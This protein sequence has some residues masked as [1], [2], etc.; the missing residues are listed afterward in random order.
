MSNILDR[1][2]KALSFKGLFCM[3]MAML[4]LF[5]C[6]GFPLFAK[7]EAEAINSAS[8]P[9]NS[10]LKT[11]ATTQRAK[12]DSNINYDKPVIVSMGDSF[13][14]GEG[15]EDFY[16]QD[17]SNEKKVQS[18][19][20]LAHRSEL[21][22]PGQ[23]KFPG[24]D[25]VTKEYKGGNWRFVASSGATTYHI[26]NEQPKD[27]ARGI[28]NQFTDE[29][30]EKKGINTK[31]Y[32]QINVFKDLEK[33]SV[34]YV[35]LTI[36]GNDAKFSAIIKEAVI[37]STYLNLSSLNNM[38]SDVWK[39]FYKDEGI[40]DNIYKTYKDIEKA[41]GKQAQIIVAGYPRLLNENGW[42]PPFSKEEAQEINRAVSNFN[43]EIERIVEQ[44]A[45]EDMKICF[46]SV[47]EEFKDRGAYSWNSYINRVYLTPQDEDLKN[48]RVSS[49]Y[50]IH[51]NKEGAK[52]YARC[53]N[54]K[55][56]EL[57]Q[58]EA[59]RIEQEALNPSEKD[60]E[61]VL[62]LDASGSMSGTPLEE[63]KSAAHKFVD[64]VLQSDANIG[65]VTYDDIAS[66]CSAMTDSKQ[67]LDNAID[68]I[69]TGGSTNI[70]DGLKMADSMLYESK[71][72][73][74]IIVLM[75]D[76]LPNCG[77]TGDSLISYANELKAKGYYIYTL[78]FFSKVSNKS[79]PEA[80]MG[81]IASEGCHYEVTD[82]ESLVFFFGDIADQ[83]SGTNFIYVRIA[84][85]V[86]V[87][88]TYNGETL[89]SVD[90]YKS[91]RTSF[92]SITFEENKK[93]ESESDDYYS[94]DYYS[95][96]Y[97]NEETED[98]QNDDRIKILRLKEGVDY[99]V[100]IEGNGEGEMDYTIGFM[101]KNG[102]YSDMRDF[103]DV[104]ITPDTVIDTVATVSD[105][106]LMYVDEDGDGEYDITYKAGVNEIAEEV[107]EEVVPEVEEEDEPNYP[108]INL[109]VIGGV[110]LL[111][112]LILIAIR[113]S[114]IKK[115]IVYPTLQTTAA[116]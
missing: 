91:T 70:E 27:F 84:C 92:G 101:D 72:T 73:K 57:A 24:L 83:I 90:N 12:V 18:Q 86:D 39:D 32:P 60:R 21:S 34:D 65:I 46:V 33:E 82:A 10:T 31:I 8:A 44:C 40:R 53:V 107:K 38:L 81:A 106:T 95:D 20:W 29:A 63:T 45:S 114:K 52:A 41:A 94:D 89:T 110:I 62:V 13:S 68:S 77:K 99:D 42:G 85:P 15:I 88:V 4:L 74:K 59:D 102:E 16:D 61:I 78:G 71:A 55:I 26:N 108:L 35:T 69:N 51:P 80:L 5:S 50:S 116:E 112:V 36:G 56:A 49:D 115:F 6:A 75:S 67:Y 3:F 11:A 37:G 79:E 97:S 105:N 54:T 100:K 25:D 14:A 23:L 2:D 58:A 103:F 104:E 66:V 1:I 43:I 113:R 87:T 17:L 98:K 111:A 28:G 109:I 93:E 19:D 76:G 47:E 96:D 64:T 7:G 30:N 48:I 9:L 22:W